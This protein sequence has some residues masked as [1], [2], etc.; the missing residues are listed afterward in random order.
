M[1][2]NAINGLNANPT[3]GRRQVPRSNV[4]FGASID[5]PV[6]ETAKKAVSGGKKVAD[7]IS[8]A[9]KASKDAIVDFAS[10]HKGKKA[11]KPIA[12][13]LTALVAGGFAIKELH[14]IVTRSNPKD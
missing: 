13:G 11:I 6:K 5:A 7:K 12:V 3:L 9:L 10:K 2:I 14:D 8:D 1:N 4:S